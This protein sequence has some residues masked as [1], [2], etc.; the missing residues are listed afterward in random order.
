MF[1]GSRGIRTG[2]VS[3]SPA[4]DLPDATP[5]LSEIMAR[6]GHVTGAVSTLY[7][8]KKYFARGFH[9]YMNPVAHDRARLQQVTAAEINA[10]ALP[11][12]R[13]HADR[14][15]FLFLHY[16]DPHAVYKPPEAKYRTMF[17]KRGDPTDSADKSLAPL[18]KQFVGPFMRAHLDRIRPGITSAEYVIS[19]Y[20]G[21]IRY[22][23]T[24]FGEVL[25]LL[26]ELGLEKE[27]LLI[28]TSD[29]GESMTEHDHFFDHVSVYEQVVRLPLLIRWP[30]RLPGGRR[31][32]ALVQ[33]IDIAPTILE[34]AGI[35][36]P[37][38]MEGRSLLPLGR[39]ETEAGYPFVVSNQALWQ[40]KRM[41]SDGRWK[42]IR[43]LDNGYW[44]APARELYDLERDPG[45]THNLVDAEPARAAELELRLRRW[46]EAELRG[47]LDPIAK[48][49]DSGL[50]SRPWVEAAAKQGGLQISYEEYRNLIDVPYTV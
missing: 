3:H 26:Q 20:D 16:W 28:V 25:D 27:T 12:L 42:L 49:A 29:H 19:Q 22:V 24:K 8:M 15:F 36:K 6:G 37:E 35:E 40:V 21:E 31:V 44:P 34:A 32:A 4:E 9:A 33:N 14:D 5:Y 23:D 11:W 50:P 41:I 38:A 13:A 47:K 7:F 30:K 10:Y 46:E 17:W 45:E 48:I 18:R 43:A 2:V 39:G 1:T